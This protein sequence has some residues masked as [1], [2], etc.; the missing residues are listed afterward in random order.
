MSS[1]SDTN[2]AWEQLRAYLEAQAKLTES[3]IA[4]V[5]KLE[6]EQRAVVSVL[7]SLRAGAEA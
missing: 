7:L 3:L 1:K 2:E 5:E 6:E 4:K